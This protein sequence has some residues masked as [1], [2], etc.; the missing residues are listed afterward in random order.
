MLVLVL[1]TALH[2]QNRIP[3]LSYYDGVVQDVIDAGVPAVLQ[4]CV[5]C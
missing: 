1:S 3:I 5:W 4:R 2:A